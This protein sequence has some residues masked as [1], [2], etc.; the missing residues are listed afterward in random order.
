MAL[1]IDE[2]GG[3]DGLVSLEDVVEMVVGDIEDEHDDDEPLIT[4]LG[5]GV[6]VVD[7]RAEIDDVAE[8]IGESFAT[9]EHGDYVDTIGGMIFNALGRVP[10]R[11][12]TVEVVPG[13]EFQVLDADP[14]RIKRV[15]I[16]EGRAGERRRRPARAGEA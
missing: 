2:Y 7:A 1:V 11:G 9:G 13:F 10:A 14:R 6:Y 3:T 16:V 8:M 12:E 4:K 5:E 15:R